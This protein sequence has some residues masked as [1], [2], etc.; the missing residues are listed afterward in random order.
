MSCKVSERDWQLYLAGD[1]SAGRLRKFELHLGSCPACQAR[2]E[3]FEQSR[4]ITLSQLPEL[5]KITADDEINLDQAVARALDPKEQAPRARL[6]WAT[7]L[8]AAAMVAIIFAIM[9]LRPGIGPN[10]E[11]DAGLSNNLPDKVAAAVVQP[12]HYE[13]RMNTSDPKVKIVW[14]FDKNLKL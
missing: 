7:A 13:L 14:V 10:S 9:W 5:A 3:E 1:M 12:E 2:R 11:A 4:Q 6:N 8:G